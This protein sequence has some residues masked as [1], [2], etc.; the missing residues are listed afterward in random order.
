MVFAG[1]PPAFDPKRE[2]SAWVLHLIVPAHGRV[3]VT[4]IRNLNP[5]QQKEVRKL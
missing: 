5:K 3:R 4:A 2:G 1:T